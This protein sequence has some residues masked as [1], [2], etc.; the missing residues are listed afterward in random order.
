MLLNEGLSQEFEKWSDSTSLSYLKMHYINADIGVKKV[1]ANGKVNYAKNYYCY[2]SFR[3]N[4]KD[5]LSVFIINF[6]IYIDDER[7]NYIMIVD[8]VKNKKSCIILGDDK[9]EN[10]LNKLT[11]YFSCKGNLLKEKYKIEM[12]DLLLRAK[13]GQITTPLYIH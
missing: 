11:N 2:M 5:S 13:R 3:L 6:G 8:Q 10:D 9:F 7:S 12:C 4:L 1:V